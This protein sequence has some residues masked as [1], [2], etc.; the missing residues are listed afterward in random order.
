[1]IITGRDDGEHLA[2]LEEVLRRLQHHGLRANKA[3]FD[4]FKEITYC[5]HDIDSNGL[6]KSKEKV[7]AVLKAP[8]PNDVAEERSSLGLINYYHRF[9]PSLS[10]A[11]HPLNQ[12]L[13]K[14]HKWKWT[15]QCDEEK[16]MINSE[17]VLAYYDPSLPLQLACD[18]FTVGIGA[19]WSH[20]MSDGTERP[21]AFASK[22]K[23]EQKYAQINK[24]A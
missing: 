7:E 10:T 12:F 16:E 19:V 8:R 9:L 23:T 5:G 4:F 22:T 2:N 17:Q 3:T 21:I 11:V 24:E 15:K 20:V 13:E 6:H 1:M 18:V 14:N